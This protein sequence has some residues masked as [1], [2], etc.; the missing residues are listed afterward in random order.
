MSEIVPF[1]KYKGQP[2]EV[3]S[4]DK[5]YC[6]WLMSQGD[7]M[8]RYSN[9]KTLI[10]NNFKEP[11][12]TPE[13]NKIQGLFLKDDI[14]LSVA[15]LVQ[16][17][18]PHQDEFDE[19]LKSAHD[20]IKSQ[21]DKFEIQS[22]Y[23]GVSDKK[24]E[25]E[26]ADVRFIVRSW[27]DISRV[28]DK[29]WVSSPVCKAFNAKIELKPSVGDDYPSILRQMKANSCNILV[30]GSY[31][32]LGVSEEDFSQMMKMSGVNTVRIDSLIEAVA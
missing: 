7:F 12:D 28:S 14:C 23:R 13:H 30:Y 24:F 5:G 16:N 19:K 31:V 9:I 18:L 20:S 15:K 1:G 25:F 22:S 27:I 26:G 17:N 32:G 6:D 3:L 10:I 29:S 4:N 21:S 11:E 2:V 8:D